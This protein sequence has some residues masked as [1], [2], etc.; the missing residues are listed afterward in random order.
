MEGLELTPD[1]IAIDPGET[2]GVALFE[3]GRCYRSIPM[4]DM[5]CL[6]LIE[7]YLSGYSFSGELVVERFRLYASK[8][9]Q[10]V[11]ST[12]R[13]VEV[14][15]A[16]KWMVHLRQMRDEHVLLIMAPADIKK[17]TAGNMRGRGIRSIVFEKDSKLKEHALDAEQLGYWR[18]IEQGRI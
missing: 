14:I 18:L 13:T 9:Q 1:L 10:Q 11:G 12:F 15:G 4:T 7:N 2:C 16:I 17:A 5:G 8:A 3:G 6:H